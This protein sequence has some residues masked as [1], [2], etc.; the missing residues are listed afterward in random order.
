MFM[1]EDFLLKNETARELYHNYAAKMPIFDFHNHLSAKEIYEDQ[2]YS[3]M[4]DIWLGGDHYKWRL[5]RAMGVPEE[6][7]TGTAADAFERFKV[8]ADTVEQ[9]IGNP[10]YHWTHLELQRYFE[11]NT[12]LSAATAKEIWEYCNEKLKTR[13]FSVRNLLRKQRVAA[14]CTTDDPTDDL[15]YHKLLQSEGFEIQVLPTFRPDRALALDKA[16]FLDYIKMLGQVTEMTLTDVNHLLT[17]LYQRLDYFIQAGCLVT[18]HSLESNIYESATEEEVNAIYRKRLAGE[19]VS[20][21]EISKYRGYILSCLGRKYAEKGLVMQLHIGAL[22]N[23]SRRMFEAVGADCGFDSMNDLNYAPE[24]SRLL[25]SMDCVGQLPRTVLYCL[26]PKDNEMLAALAGNFQGDG[27]K[28]KV[29]F[30][31]AWW[32]NDH[33]PGMERQM[34][35]LSSLGLISTFIGMLT[36]SRSFLSFPRHEYF[37]RILCNLIG[38]WVEDGEYPKNIEYLGRLVENISYQNAVNYFRLKVSQ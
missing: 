28:G 35:T 18:D 9:T 26:N 3:N 19:T 7:V 33:K 5:L 29:Q 31:T 4:T 14:L 15:N 34:E 32:F 6:L 20:A 27:I 12:P 37:R 38:T 10:I 11:I 16:D 8:W 36:D 24:L 17:A 22:R 2:C 30:G 1:N 13:E 23:N 25:D 21:S